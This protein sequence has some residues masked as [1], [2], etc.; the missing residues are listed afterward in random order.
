MTKRET[1]LA[2][3]DEMYRECVSLEVVRLVL[4][5]NYGLIATA[6]RCKSVHGRFYI[7]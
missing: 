3:M 4:M 7:D 2:D 5:E 6:P 1:A